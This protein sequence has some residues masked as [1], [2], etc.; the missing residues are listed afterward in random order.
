MVIRAILHGWW[1]SLVRLAGA[2][3]TAGTLPSG[4]L[5]YV[6]DGEKLARFLISSSQFSSTMVKPSALLPN[7]KNGETSVFRHGEEPRG[8]LWEIAESN[9]RLPEGRRLHGA[10][11]ITAQDV[12]TEE[13]EVKAEEPPPRHANIIGWPFSSDDPE[14][15]KAEQKEKAVLLA[16][17]AILVRR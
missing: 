9:L 13:L 5:E 3:T 4:L 1:Q 2:C 7:P 17:R 10:A 8:R 12:R 11:I 16:S 15:R 14:W 6:D